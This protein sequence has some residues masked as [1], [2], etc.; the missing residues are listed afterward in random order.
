MYDWMFF[1][2]EIHFRRYGDMEIA[3]PNRD[4]D[5]DNS[6]YA[7]IKHISQVKTSV[8]KENG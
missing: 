6:N 4:L 3:L 1:S 7:T 2:M 8:G 5:P